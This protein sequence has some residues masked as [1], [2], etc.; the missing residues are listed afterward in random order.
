MNGSGLTL[1][2]KPRAELGAMFEDGREWQ[3]WTKGRHVRIANDG[4]LVEDIVAIGGRLELAHDND[5]LNILRA[6]TIGQIVLAALILEDD[7]DDVVTEMPLFMD[8][9]Q[10]KHEMES[11][12]RKEKGKHLLRAALS[13]ER[14]EGADVVHDVVTAEGGEDGVRSSRVSA[15]NIKTTIVAVPVGKGNLL[16]EELQEALVVRSAEIVHKH[17]LL[18]LLA[19]HAIEHTE[20]EVR[21]D[22]HVAALKD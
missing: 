19:G 10:A 4:D 5:N 6:H 1:A 14:E 2:K 15:A 13:G 9:F 3:W 8:L 22:T 7:H 12:Q 18:G 16:T 21:G 20:L 17:F 11:R